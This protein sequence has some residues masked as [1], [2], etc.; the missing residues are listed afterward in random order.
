MTARRLVLAALVLGIVL[1]GAANARPGADNDP[2]VVR[3]KRGTDSVTLTGRLTRTGDCCSFVFKAHA[4]QALTWRI[5]GPATRQTITY[6]DGHTDGPGLA[7]PLPLPAEGAYVL[8][9]HPNLMADGAF[10]RFDFGNGVLHRVFVADV[11]RERLAAGRLEIANR[12]EA[13]RGRVDVVS[14][15]GETQRGRATDSGRAARDEDGF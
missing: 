3:M 10:G 1:G 5:T 12:I 15:F 13:A 6:P 7:N 2:I 4:G 14:G 9:V 8:T 11:E